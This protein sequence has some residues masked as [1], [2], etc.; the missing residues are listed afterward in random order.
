MYRYTID[1]LNKAKPAD[2][3]L[4]A[5]S[6]K[7]SVLKTH[8]KYRVV[9]CICSC[10]KHKDCLVVNLRSGEVKSCGC[11]KHNNRNHDTHGLSKHP[12]YRVWAQMNSRCKY[13]G[14]TSFK[15]YG[16]RGISVCKKWRG[17]FKAFYDWAIS[18]GWKRGLQIDRRRNNGNYTPSNCRIVT[19]S[20]NARNKR[21]TT[22][23]EFGGKR[24]SIADW[25]DLLGLY[26]SL[27]M[28]RYR[29]GWPIEDILS[30]NI[31]KSDRVRNK[32]T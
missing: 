17:D 1:Q 18:N 31:F 26:Y 27:I 21:N 12:L 4:T 28:Y 15:N 8:G 20:Q 2:S 16:G 3:R 24:L 22:F 23:L 7:E 29:A 25:A 32:S 10:G 5:I 14:Q 6:F 11:A 9:Y 13:K 19:K 30:K